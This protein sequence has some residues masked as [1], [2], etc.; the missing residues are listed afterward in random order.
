MFRNFH[1]NERHPDSLGAAEDFRVGWM[2]ERLTQGY[3]SS[4]IKS[5]LPVVQTTTTSTDIFADR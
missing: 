4:V 3:H 5:A 1:E 2:L